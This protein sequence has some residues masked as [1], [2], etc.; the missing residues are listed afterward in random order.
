LYR[1]EARALDSDVDVAPLELVQ[2]ILDLIEH[3][4]RLDRLGPGAAQ[5]RHR[6]L[7][8]AQ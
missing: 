6:V 5:A 8:L 2:V 7:R 4:E 3:L 1:L